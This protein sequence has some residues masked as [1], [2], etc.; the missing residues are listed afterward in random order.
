MSTTINWSGVRFLLH[1]QTHSPTKEFCDAVARTCYEAGAPI[2]LH[3]SPAETTYN[4]ITV[5]CICEP[6]T[7]YVLRWEP[8]CPAFRK[9][10]IFEIRRIVG[11]QKPKTLSEI[12][13]DLDFST[14]KWTAVTTPWASA[15]PVAP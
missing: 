1:E 6:P 10:S 4:G 13:L 14:A 15:T 8:S 9:H 12:A 2:C 3:V 7:G 11:A 5:S